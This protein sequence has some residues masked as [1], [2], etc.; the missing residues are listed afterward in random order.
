MSDPPLSLAPQ[1]WRGSPDSPHPDFAT[2]LSTFETTSTADDSKSSASACATPRTANSKRSFSNEQEDE[3]AEVEY[4]T[5]SEQAEAER[6]MPDIRTTSP[7]P[8]RPIDSKWSEGPLSLLLPLNRT[9]V[10]GDN[11][12]SIAGKAA[13]SRAQ[14]SSSRESCSV[15]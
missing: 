4:K 7:S 1:R 8:Q 6:D 10:F 3:T 11:A 2:L 5:A 9:Q 12:S 15:R 14:G 13:V